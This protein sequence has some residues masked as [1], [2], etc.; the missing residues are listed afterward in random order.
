MVTHEA[1]LNIYDAERSRPLHLA[2]REG[3]TEVVKALLATGAEGLAED[4]LGLTAQDLA[5]KHCH[6]VTAKVFVYE[7]KF[8]CGEIAGTGLQ[9]KR[10]TAPPIGQMMNMEKN[11]KV[12]SD[13]CSE[14]Q[15]CGDF[16]SSMGGCRTFQPRKRITGPRTRRNKEERS[17]SVASHP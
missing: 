14:H 2:A 11:P 6:E 16:T 13:F 5:I 12:E 9:D 15:F 17:R 7:Q 3:H 1:A 8:L 10:K 4:K